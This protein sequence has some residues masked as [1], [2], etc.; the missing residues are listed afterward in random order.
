MAVQEV[1][2][3]ERGIAA[4]AS[5]LRALAVILPMAVESLGGFVAAI[6]IRTDVG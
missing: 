5:V 3:S 2:A 6:A 1:F 4:I